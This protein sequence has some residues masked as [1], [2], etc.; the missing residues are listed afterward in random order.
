MKRTFLLL[1]SIAVSQVSMAQFTA[2]NLVV[3]KST[4]YVDQAPD[5]DV[6]YSNVGS[7]TLLEM[8]LAGGNQVETAVSGF[9]I[10]LTASTVNNG[11]LKL[12]ADK[13]YLTMYGY[14]SGSL[15]AVPASGNLAAST[16]ARTMLLVNSAK[17]S[18]ALD[19]PKNANNEVVHSATQARSAIAFNAGTNLYGVY[20]GGGTGGTYS[21]LQYVEVNTLT[22]AIT[23]P[24]QIAALNTA[25]LG[26]FNNQLYNATGLTSNPTSNKFNQIGTG[27]PTTAATATD[28]TSVVTDVKIPGDF[29]FFGTNLL[30]IADETA[31]TGGIRKYYNN[32]TTWVAKGIVNSGITGDLGIRGFTGR[33]E[34]GKV[35]L[36]G[37]TG[38]SKGNSI[39]K[40]VDETAASATISNAGTDVTITTLAT[41]TASVGFRGISFTPNSTITL[42]VSLTDFSAK[43]VNNA[44][45][46][47]WSTASEQNNKGFE[48]QHSTDGQTFTTIGEVTGKNNSNQKN[49]YSFTD[50][51]PVAGTNYYQLKQVDNNG[52]FKIYGPKAVSISFS[53]N[54]LSVYANSSAVN[55]NLNSALNLNNVSVTVVNANGQKV[56]NSNVQI[57]KGA[58][59]IAIPATLTKGV[60]VLSIQG[61]G[62]NDVKKFIVK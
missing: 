2:D 21:G 26:I 29:V 53:N 58:N 20:L 50:K 31:G 35:V 30:Y 60:Y 10:G 27:L 61:N 56:A 52:D 46:L 17:I 7:V 49:T 45:Q 32:G 13:K 19:I 25:G 18:T 28:L 3:V 54:D 44:V 51:T 16:N 5:P 36:Y 9:Y 12:S 43:S 24:V 14:N 4:I 1:L 15:P 55:V 11:N 47:N 6:T 38:I 22:N 57:V 33:L 37:V 40:I 62:L 39:V 34:G 59:T 23:A 48:V 8:D 41:A 42:P